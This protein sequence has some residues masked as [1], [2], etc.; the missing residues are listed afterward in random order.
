M[1]PDCRRQGALADVTPQVPLPTLAATVGD[2]GICLGPYGCLGKPGSSRN[3]T[4]NLGAGTGSGVRRIRRS[5]RAPHWPILSHQ[6][7]MHRLSGR[8]RNVG[9]AAYLPGMSDVRCRPRQPSPRKDQQQDQASS[10]DVVP[11]I[12]EW[13][14]E[15][16]LFILVPAAL[17]ASAVTVAIG[18]AHGAAEGWALT[19][20]LA[21]VAAVLWWFGYTRRRKAHGAQRDQA[22]REQLAIAVVDQMTWQEFEDHC[23][24][25]LLALGY[26][27]VAKTRGVSRERAVDI[28]AVA[29]DDTAVAV[30]CKHWKNSVGV[31]RKSVV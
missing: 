15:W 18:R 14:R 2:I 5:L 29:P 4:G 1:K 9:G 6:S 11:V 7:Q 25:V 27:S 3:V 31:D 10:V 8:P 19:I 20:A 13:L 17:V 16:G 24:R 21:S 30:E 26:Q 12:P 23:V 22:L 28:T